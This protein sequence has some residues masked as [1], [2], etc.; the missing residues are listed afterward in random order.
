MPYGDKRLFALLSILFPFVDLRN[1]F[2][3][4]HVF[5]RSHFTKG[6]LSRAGISGDPDKLAEHANSLPN[7]QLLEGVIN[8]AKQDLL[9]AEWLNRTFATAEARI[10]YRDRHLLGDVPVGLEGFA[11]FHAARKSALKT[12]LAAMLI[13]PVHP[14]S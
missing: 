6:R 5:P 13:K 1:Q 3:I 9:P 12:R 2:H 4:D 8:T 11:A 10:D 7:L 14:N